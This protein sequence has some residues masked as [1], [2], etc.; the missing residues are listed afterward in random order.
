MNR[1]R[2]PELDESRLNMT[3]KLVGPRVS[4]LTEGCLSI[5]QTPEPLEESLPR[6]LE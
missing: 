2:L 3:L 5:A 1:L 6:M 4:P